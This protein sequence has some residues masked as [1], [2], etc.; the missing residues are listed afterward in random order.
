M[1][2]ADG[3]GCGVS[4]DSFAES[5]RA[6][7]TSLDKTVKAFRTLKTELPTLNSSLSDSVLNLVP[8]FNLRFP[9]ASEG[10]RHPILHPCP[11]EGFGSVRL[12]GEGKGSGSGC[13]SRVLV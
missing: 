7:D 10:C 8:I 6:G 9:T 13:R 12:W 2:K 1:G 3:Q 5:D 4:L 11:A